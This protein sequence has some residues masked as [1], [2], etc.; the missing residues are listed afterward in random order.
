M[1]VGRGPAV[2]GQARWIRSPGIDGALAL[3]WVPFAVVAHALNGSSDS[4]FLFINATFLLSFY[5]QPLTLPLV[6]GD[7]GEVARHRSLY[8]WSPVVFLVAIVVGI[9]VALP[10]VAFVADLWKYEQTLMQRFGLTRPQGR[11]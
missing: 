8:L 9:Q 6:Y 5:H 3:C 7:P 2:L 1:W 10:V 4:L 11:Q